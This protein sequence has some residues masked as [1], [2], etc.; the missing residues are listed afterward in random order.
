MGQ[1]AELKTS[2]AVKVDDLPELILTATNHFG[3]RGVFVN[4][5]FGQATAN[6]KKSE[7]IGRDVWRYE[8]DLLIDWH[9]QT[10]GVEITI[11]VTAGTQGSYKQCQDRCQ[12]LLQ[13]IQ[14]SSERLKQSGDEDSSSDIYGSAR[15]AT[16]ADLA[17][18]GYLN[19]GHER[20]ILGPGTNGG[21]ISV[22]EAQTAMH[23]IVCGP[24]G[25]GKSSTVYIPN[26]I[27]RTDI[28]A[29]VTEATAGDE[30]PDLFQKTSGFR[31]LSGQKVYKFNPADLTSHRIN[32][33]QYVKTY[34]QA[35]QIASLIV[36][37]TSSKFSM[38]DQIWENSERHL[39]T[40]LVLHAVGERGDL[41][42]IRRLLREGP[43]GLAEIMAKSQYV[44]AEKEYQ[45]FYKGSSDG[46]RK[47]V[48]SGLMQR[49]NL[50]VNP[51]IVALTETT[52]IDLEAL[53]NERF[54][55]YLAVPAHEDRLKPL[56][57]LI[58]NLILNLSLEKRFKYPLSLFLD[59]FTNFGYVPGIAE[60]LTIIRHRNIPAVL[61]FQDYVQ[62]RKVYGEEDAGLLFNQP[63]T[64]IFFRPRDLNV[65]KKISESLGNRTVIERKVTSSGQIQEREISRQLM[66]PGEIMALEEGKAIAFTPSTPPI[67]LKMYKWQQYK[68]ATEQPP[69]VFRTLKVNE[70]LVRRCKETESKPEWQ[71]QW[72]E[73]RGKDSA[74]NSKE[75]PAPY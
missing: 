12:E 42:F 23:A 38:G 9:K 17:K 40:V 15:W 32:P 27:D 64:K 53:T 52:D 73:S 25:T 66:N 13:A 16:E 70:E 29:I 41:G 4:K 61:G 36:K 69:P 55:F 58:F 21:C 71:E 68:S 62:M 44:E 75:K 43:E 35:A 30:L 59:E 49:L 1:R 7:K 51:R 11:A 3:W 6:Y 24:T 65:A 14:R 60:K 18:A 48:V 33:L 37:N 26:L 57:A 39:L 28:S 31:Q 54:T 63:G 67:L 22:P 50:W 19:N 2:V 8:F 45:G 10:S 47:G 56:A 20:F 5:R 34:D 74:D 72:D 46:F